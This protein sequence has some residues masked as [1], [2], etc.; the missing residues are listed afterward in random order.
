MFIALFCLVPQFIMSEPVVYGLIGRTV[1]I[2][3]VPNNTE[4]AVDW[5]ILYATS[6]AHHTDHT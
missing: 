5:K 2:S 6:I 3:C 4:A 1:N